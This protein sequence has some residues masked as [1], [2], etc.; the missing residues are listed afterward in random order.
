MSNYHQ[1]NVF[2]LDGEVWLEYEDWKHGQD[3]VWILN[4]DNGKAMLHQGCG[5]EV[6]VYELNLAKGLLALL[7][8]LKSRE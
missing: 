8:W 1:L 6:D 4:P 3:W 2:E 5:D 7:A